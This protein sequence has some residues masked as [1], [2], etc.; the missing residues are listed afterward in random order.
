MYQLR[1]L[2]SDIDEVKILTWIVNKSLVI[3]NVPFGYLLHDRDTV[4]LLPR[5]LLRTK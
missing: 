1:G 4:V 2:G 3:E 5:S